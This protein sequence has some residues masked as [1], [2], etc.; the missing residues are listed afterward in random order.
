MREQR[1]QKFM[2]RLGRNLANP[3][4]VSSLEALTGMLRSK[5]PPANVTPVK[6]KEPGIEAAPSV[7]VKQES[8]VKPERNAQVKRT[9][10]FRQTVTSMKRSTMA[11]GG[12]PLKRATSFKSV[13]A[14]VKSVPTSVK[15]PMAPLSSQM[16]RVQKQKLTVPHSPNFTNRT[17]QPQAA[18][19]TVQSVTKTSLRKIPARNAPKL[20]A[21]GSSSKQTGAEV[22]IRVVA[23]V[24]KRNSSSW[25]IP[26]T[27]DRKISPSKSPSS[28]SKANSSIH[29]PNVKPFIR[30][31]FSESK[32]KPTVANRSTLLSR[33]VS[34]A[35]IR[36]QSSF[37][38]RKSVAPSTLGKESRLS[39]S[40]WGVPKEPS[41]KYTFFF[42]YC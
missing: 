10:S 39:R 11:N 7:P 16:A 5:K 9:L 33:S 40:T 23:Q 31:S 42:L 28:T 27:P 17:R 1:K 32:A 20:T 35:A 25:M 12:A 30:K 8:G 14:S 34:T 4:S 18:K 24:N 38:A 2:V 41:E 15:K 13:P 3:L 22:S 26:L 37:I 19:P 36:P 29:T 6:A 21:A